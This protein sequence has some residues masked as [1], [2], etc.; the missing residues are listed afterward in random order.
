MFEP[1]RFLLCDARPFSTFVFGHCLVWFVVCNRCPI[2]R[3][4]GL[5]DFWANSISSVCSFLSRIRCLLVLLVWDWF[6]LFWLCHKAVDMLWLTKPIFCFPFMFV[7]T[8]P[9][10]H[11]IRHVCLSL[12]AFYLLFFVF[13]LL[14]RCSVLLHNSLFGFVWCLNS[15]VFLS[16]LHEWCD[17]RCLRDLTS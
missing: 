2:I 11:K 17:H 10:E 15:F 6:T 8:S 12:F 5:F 16:C 13:P 7:C 4:F 9:H 3:F 1:I 14:R